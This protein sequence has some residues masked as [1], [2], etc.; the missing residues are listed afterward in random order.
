MHPVL[1]S[2]SVNVTGRNLKLQIVQSHLSVVGQLNSVKKNELKRGDS[3]CFIINVPHQ[4][5]N[6][7]LNELGSK[8]FF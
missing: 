2:S 5:P 6:D 4:L 1:D 8:Y 3:F 7:S